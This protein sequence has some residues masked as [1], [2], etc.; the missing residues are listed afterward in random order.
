MRKKRKA[1]PKDPLNVMK[2]LRLLLLTKIVERL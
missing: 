2:E 1:K